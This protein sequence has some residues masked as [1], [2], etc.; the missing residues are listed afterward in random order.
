MRIARHARLQKHRTRENPR[1]PN[2]IRDQPT[3]GFAMRIACK[4]TGHRRAGFTFG[5]AHLL[6]PTSSSSRA[7]IQFLPTPR[8]GRSGEA[9]T[10][11]TMRDSWLELST[12]EIVM[13]LPLLAH[14]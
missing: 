11:C 12:D 9:H 7:N 1:A 8:R 13:G 10:S 2:Q 4:K 6:R 3:P 5:Q 14:L